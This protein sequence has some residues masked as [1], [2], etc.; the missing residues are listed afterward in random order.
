MK[1]NNFGK[2]IQNFASFILVVT[3]MIFFVIFIVEASNGDVWDFGSLKEIIILEGLVLL[4]GFTA[5]IL[6]YGFGE[7]IIRLQKICEI[8]EDL[9]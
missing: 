7:I 6:F 4:I 3:I 9:S 5:F 1:I 2:I 8:A